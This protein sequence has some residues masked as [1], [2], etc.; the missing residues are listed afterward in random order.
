[1]IVA[2]ARSDPDSDLDQSMATPGPFEMLGATTSS[3]IDNATF[4]TL[5]KLDETILDLI[6]A[7]GSP[8]AA[9]LSIDKALVDFEMIGDRTCRRAFKNIATSWTLERREVDALIAMA[10]ALIWKDPGFRQFIGRLG[11]KLEKLGWTPEKAS[12]AE[13]AA[14][15]RLLSKQNT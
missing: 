8:G 4:G 1:M 3:A 13:R 10:E 2:N 9:T 15:N 12:A 6:K 7:T 14:C 11:D 5:Q